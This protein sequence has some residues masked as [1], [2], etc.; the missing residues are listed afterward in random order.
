MDSAD[1]V[2]RGQRSLGG[3]RQRVSSALRST[4]HVAFPGIV[5]R[6]H[7]ALACVF[8]PASTRPFAVRL[9]D[10]TTEQPVRK[11]PPTFTLVLPTPWALREM[12]LPPSELRLGEAFVRGAFDV[13]GDLETAVAVGRELQDR[14]IGRAGVRA[15]AAL[16]R[17]PRVESELHAAP[18][19]SHARWMHAHSLRRDAAAVRAHYEVGNDFY[20]LWLDRRLVY[21]CA[22]FKTGRESIDAAQDAKLEHICRKLRLRAGEHLLDIGCGWG[23]LIMYAAARYGVRAL[24]VTLSQAQASLAR[25]RIAAAGLADQCSVE[26]ADYRC[27]PQ[28][29]PFDKVVSVGMIEHVGRTQLR[30]YAKQVR[31]LTAPGGLFLNHGIVAAPE[32]EGLGAAVARR[33][34]RQGTFIDR[35]VFPD[36]ELQTSARWCVPARPRDSKRGM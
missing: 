5:G 35:Y 2:R 24:G 9:W 25:E 22:Y 19:A 11:E 1:V 21:S 10:G 29:R 30:A 27:L 12:L 20:A 32:P 14:L 15:L 23:A 16:V 13:E 26:V 34:W 6:T 28:D 3:R 7:E 17:L 8:G 4:P 33:V 31:E 36:G 18:R